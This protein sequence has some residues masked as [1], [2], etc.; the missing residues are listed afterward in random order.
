MRFVNS[1]E[2]FPGF[3]VNS[4]P[5]TLK[6]TCPSEGGACAELQ[7][8]CLPFTSALTSNDDYSWLTV[9][10]DP[11]VTFEGQTG[12][13][14]PAILVAITSIVGWLA[15]GTYFGLLMVDINH[16]RA[17][18][19]GFQ[20][21]IWQFLY[22]GIVAAFGIREASDGSCAIRRK[23]FNFIFGAVLGIVISFVE[24]RKANRQMRWVEKQMR[25][26]AQGKPVADETEQDGSDESDISSVI[27]GVKSKF[28]KLMKNDVIDNSEVLKTEV[29][30]SLEK[31]RL[32]TRS[33]Q[34]SCL[35]SL[36]F[37]LLMFAAL[38]GL[39]NTPLATCS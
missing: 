8:A 36:A 10:G 22:A 20:A 14:S 5:D 35:A 12:V 11:A 13:W 29:G 2:C 6:C 32:Q 26:V 1:I 21:L 23:I 33:A 37:F 38:A 24:V 18:L 9:R 31:F 28:Q 4:D 34:R 17:P 19:A 27:D 30:K 39:F 3:K 25:A 15:I 7:D 16:F